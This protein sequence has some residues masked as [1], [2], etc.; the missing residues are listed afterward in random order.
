MIMIDPF[1]TVSRSYAPVHAFPSL[2]E[3]HDWP[4]HRDT[5]EET[6]G[7]VSGEGRTIR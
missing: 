2:V 7:P 1:P 4:T 6:Q 3:V 5:L